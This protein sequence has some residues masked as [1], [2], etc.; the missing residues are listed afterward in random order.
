VVEFGECF[1]RESAASAC[2]V[3]GAEEAPERVAEEGAALELGV[4][5]GVEI[6]GVWVE[7]DWIDRKVDVAG[8][9]AVGEALGRGDD[10]EINRRGLFTEAPEQRGKDECVEEIRRDDAEGARCVFWR[11][12]LRLGE[13]AGKRDQAASEGDG[14]GFGA[15]G[16]DH[17]TAAAD[18]KR[19][20]KELAKAAEGV[21]HGGLRD[22]GAFRGL[23][24]ASLACEGIE[25]DQ[26]VEVDVV[27]AF[28]GMNATH[29]YMETS[30]WIHVNWGLRFGTNTRR[31]SWKHRRKYW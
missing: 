29:V 20:V 16:E 28:H 9:E 21:A 22:A 6:E 17:A 12:G 14:E 8:F 10:G 4:D 23:G 2:G 1:E 31:H 26:E 24:D 19:V 15:R 25:G 5:L 3:V 11:E 18:Q 7:E 30:H 13:C 27:E